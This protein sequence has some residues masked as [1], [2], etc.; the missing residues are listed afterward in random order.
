MKFLGKKAN[1]KILK[2]NLAYKKGQGKKNKILKK[3]L[4]EEQ[5]GFCAYTEL[6]I[7]NTEKSLISA[8]VEHFNTTLKYKDDYYNYYA[9]L[10]GANLSKKKKDAKYKETAKAVKSFFGSLFFQ[11]DKEFQKRIRYTDGD[12]E[13]IDENDKEARDLIDFLGL[14]NPELHKAR[15]YNRSTTFLLRFQPN[16]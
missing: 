1:S 7:G 16:D 12:Y 11:D 3:L 2:E 13:E 6:Y 9:V 4:L 5:K 14:N 15:A 10:R 8:E